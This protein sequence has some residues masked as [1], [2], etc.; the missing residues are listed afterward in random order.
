[1][2][3]CFPLHD[4]GLSSS[5]YSILLLMLPDSP[6]HCSTLLC[7]ATLLFTLLGFPFALFSFS[8]AFLFQVQGSLCRCSPL[9]G[10]VDVLLFV[11]KSCTTPLHSFLQ[12]L[13]MVGSQKSKTYIFS[14]SFFPFVYCHFFCFQYHVFCS[15]VLILFA[16]GLWCKAYY[17]L[18]WK[19]T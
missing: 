10:D 16:F 6:L 11:E 15:F 14:I 4:V 19:Q 1:M 17:K 18:F 5:C 8:A 7:D 2:L 13:G 12:E 3:L 9:C